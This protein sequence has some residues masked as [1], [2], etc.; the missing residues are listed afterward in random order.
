MHKANNNKNE[1]EAREQRFVDEQHKQEKAERRQE[2]ADREAMA[3]LP[4]EYSEGSLS[5]RFTSQYASTLRYVEEWGTWLHWDGC[6]WVKSKTYPFNLARLVAREASI[7][8]R[9]ALNQ[10]AATIV[11]SNRV[12]AAIESLA[13]KNIEHLTPATHFDADDWLLNTPGGIVDLRTG[14]LLPQN[15]SKLMTK[16]TTVAPDFEMPTPLWDSFLAT[17]LQETPE[18]TAMSEFLQR[19]SGYCLTGSTREEV[20]VFIF[21]PGGAGKTTFVETVAGCLGDYATVAVM[22]SLTQRKNTISDRHSTDIAKLRGAR[23]A[24]ASETEKDRYW[25]EAKLKELTGGD[26]I[27]ARLMRQDNEDFRPKCK[28]VLYGNHPPKLRSIEGMD[29]RLLMIG[30]AHVVPV[31]KRDNTL[32]ERLQAEAPGILAWAIQGCLDWQRKGL[33]PPDKVRAATAAY[34]AEQEV[35]AHWMEECVERTE[36]HTDKETSTRLYRSYKT[37]CQG[38]GERY[39]S[40]REFSQTLERLGVKKVK[41]NKANMFVGIK[42]T[43]Q[44]ADDSDDLPGANNDNQSAIFGTATNGRFGSFR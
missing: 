31:D 2:R 27:T 44:D 38:N 33:S 4:P 35:V 43:W 29:R 3:E 26:T 18:Q 5:E 32:K 10:R 37:W 17:A 1:T 39:L 20:L 6:R 16:C 8:L 23:L 22:E 14:Q 11:Y 15:P 30:F 21:G 9:Q 40:Q 12:V 41:S 28:P 36:N 13:R 34:F 24:R 42:L 7:E 19:L 25:S